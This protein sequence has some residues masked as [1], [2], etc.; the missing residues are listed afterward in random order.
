MS[1][2]GGIQFTHAFI[3]H[4]VVNYDKA[5]ESACTKTTDDGSDVQPNHIL[6]EPTGWRRHTNGTER[7]KT[8]YNDSKNVIVSHPSLG[9]HRVL[10]VRVKQ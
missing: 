1:Q 8:K 10:G 5:R 6:S 3:Y 7:N 2:V 9:E 4:F